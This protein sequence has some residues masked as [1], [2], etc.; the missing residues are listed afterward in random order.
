MELRLPLFQFAPRYTGI[1]N[2]RLDLACGDES[3]P[4]AGPMRWLPMATSS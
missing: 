3:K 4:F 2:S 1:E